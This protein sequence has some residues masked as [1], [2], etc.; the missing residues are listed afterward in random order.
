M[1]WPLVAQ[2]PIKN[3]TRFIVKNDESRQKYCIYIPQGK[4]RWHS[5]HVVYI[6]P[7]LTYL[8]G[9]VPPTLA[10]G[11]IQIHTVRLKKRSRLEINFWIFV[12][13][14]SASSL[15]NLLH[16]LRSRYLIPWYLFWLV[17]EPTPLKNMIVK[18]DHFPRVRG[19][20]KKKWV[21][22]T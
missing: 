8:L 1:T 3:G 2:A 9:T 4:S 22:T 18:L 21:A 6:S 13:P 7:V 12:S 16:I 10:M 19:E 5:Y 14:S 11:Y 17:V 20:N 15:L